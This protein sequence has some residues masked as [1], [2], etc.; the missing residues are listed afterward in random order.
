MRSGV[1][2]T[3]MPYDEEPELKEIARLASPAHIEPFDLD[4][5]GVMD[6]L[7]GDLGQFVPGDHHKGAVVWLRGKRDGTYFA[8]TLTGWPRVADVE[9]ADFDGDG[10]PDLAVAAFGWR[11]TGD[12]TILKNTTTDYDA[13]A[14]SPVQV[15]PR[16][17]AIHAVPVDINADG[18][19]D[20]VALFSQEHETVVAFLNQGGLRFQAQT[21]YT[22]PH[23]NWGSSGI[24]VVDLNKN[25]R[26]DVL[27]THGDS[28]D[29]QIVKPYHGIQWLENRGSFPFVEHT[30][31]GLPGVHR[32]QAV[33]LDG[34]GDLDIVACA[35]SQPGDPILAELPSVVWLEQ[36]RPGSFEKHVIEVG[37]P[38]HATLDVG[39]Y[40][41]D[42]DVDIV[43]GNFSF[44]E[45][46]TDAVEIFENTR[47]R[48]SGTATR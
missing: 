29:D 6:F 19:M 7:I 42:G 26:L 34:D 8:G 18:L 46:L 36:T 38:R 9:A 43:V 23:P 39:D 47:F 44:G 33:D 14:F 11:R 24:E 40:D 28:F 5:D 35:L 17:G 4:H 37:T 16:T 12:F 41:G 22:A 1:I 2:A 48:R 13:P 15:D 45:P 27:L 31:A 10:K 30:L 3:A 21:I 20:V 25:G 32:A